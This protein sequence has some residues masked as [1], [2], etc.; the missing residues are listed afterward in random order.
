[1]LAV[2]CRS[3][4]QVHRVSPINGISSAEIASFALSKQRGDTSFTATD[5]QWSH[6]DPSYI[7]TSSTNGSLIIFNIEKEGPGRMSELSNE[8]STR[9]VNR[10]AW[11][12]YEQYTLAAANQDSTVRIYDRRLDGDKS[13]V[14]TISPRSDACRDI[15][16][17]PHDSN[18]FAAVFD[19]GNLIVWDKR[20]TETPF[21]KVIGAHTLNCLAISFCL[22]K[23]WCVATGG[24]DKSLK[25]WDISRSTS[26]SE[27]D[28]SSGSLMRPTHV[29]HTADGVGRIA[30]RPPLSVASGRECMQLAAT[31]ID[32]GDISIWEVGSPHIPACTL[33][34]HTAICTGISWLDTAMSDYDSEQYKLLCKEAKG[35]SGGRDSAAKKVVLEGPERLGVYQHI[36]SIQKDGKILVQ[37]LRNGYFPRQHISSSV[38]AIASQGHLAYQTSRVHRGDPLGLF[39]STDRYTGMSPYKIASRLAL[40]PAM[41][42][43]NPK[44]FGLP[45]LNRVL[46]IAE[47]VSQTTTSAQDNNSDSVVE[48]AATMKDTTD[49][50]IDQPTGKSATLKSLVKHRLFIS[51]LGLQRARRRAEVVD[52]F[53]RTSGTSSPPRQ[54]LRRSSLEPSAINTS[55]DS[56]HAL[57]SSSSTGTIY[58]GLA[59]IK[60]LTVAQEICQG[61]KCGGAEGGPFDPAIMSLLAKLYTVGREGDSNFQ[62][63]NEEFFDLSEEEEH[64]LNRSAIHRA[65]CAC[66]HN[67]KVAKSVGLLSHASS[68]EMLSILI[69]VLKVS[70]KSEQKSNI[71]SMDSAFPDLLAAELVST[72]LVQFLERGDCQHFVVSCEVLRNSGLLDIV[73]SGRMTAEIGSLRQRE[74]YE[75]YYQLLTKLE[76][77]DAATVLLKQSMDEY[78]SAL[79]KKG[80][81]IHITCAKCGKELSN[82][83]DSADRTSV[84]KAEGSFCIKCRKCVGLCS[85]CC[86]VVEGL[87]LWCPVC[88]HG[89]HSGCIKKWFFKNSSCPSGCGHPCQLSSAVS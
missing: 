43:E 11:S 77:Y 44:H 75:T 59:E 61:A 89:G 30:W 5:V 57:I 70:S 7:A 54:K 80:T 26:S 49:G 71:Y 53:I 74:A 3:H 21:V 78:I 15:Q 65:R 27:G 55:A 52:L 13:C 48:P 40:A 31:S 32:R 16:F 8:Q 6:I 24:R 33:K 72:Q 79:N 2:A 81:L 35:K 18:I 46:T 62:T 58:M 87:Y 76:L 9:A 17:S 69:P 86:R 36:L 73:T 88:C 34:G 66:Q 85:L 23:N 64:P 47:H 39:V 12:P 63:D 67:F 10:I 68:W 84:S 14:T 56:T 38:V 51:R 45:L 25:I 1:M 60:S 42:K 20:N 22:A 28:I 41:F 4:V 19:S 29:L 83:I 37:D 82:S 50:K